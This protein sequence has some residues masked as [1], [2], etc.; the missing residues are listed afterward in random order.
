MYA[1]IETG[2][3]QYRVSPGQTVEVELLPAEPGATVTLNRVLLVSAEGDTTVGQPVVPGGAVVA[4]V[5]GEGRGKKVIVFKYKS[6]KRYRRTTGH[7]QDYT[8]LTV[9][10]IQAKGESLVQ[11]DERKRF[12]RQAQRAVNRY[13]RKLLAAFDALIS[14]IIAETGVTAD[15]IDVVDVEDEEPA[16]EAAAETPAPKA[17]RA[18]KP[19]AVTTTESSEAKAEKPASDTAEK[20]EKNE[21][22]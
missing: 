14:S 10:D 8:Y 2:G 16:A 17:T 5:I 4:T 12:E 9:T 11:D 7:R 18:A 3:K 20:P 21:S 1:V 19:S 22:K 13:E 6:K 15:D